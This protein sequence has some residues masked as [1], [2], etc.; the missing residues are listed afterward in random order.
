[1]RKFTTIFLILVF[2]MTYAQKIKEKKGQIYVDGKELFFVEKLEIAYNVDFVIKD[3]SG[4][5]LIKIVSRSFYD[6]E[7]TC[8]K[9][10]PQ[11]KT[12]VSVKGCDVYYDEFSFPGLEEYCES[13]VYPKEKAVAKFVIDNKLIDTETGLVD[14]EY[15][16]KFMDRVGKNYSR[17][18]EE[19]KG[20][21]VIVIQNNNSTP[22]QE[23]QEGITIKKGN[24]KVNIGN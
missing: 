17:R 22:V 10:D 24:V 15:A 20:N 5:V 9:F 21:K 4:N 2:G 8:T 16:K 14:L 12:Q 3:L 19:I 18:R 7:A 13:E 1:M 6:S 11:T 23:E